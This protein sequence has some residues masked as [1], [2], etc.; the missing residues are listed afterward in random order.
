[1]YVWSGVA[2]YLPEGAVREVLSFVASH[3]SP[4]SSILFDYCFREVIE[5]DDSYYGARE[6]LHQVRAIGEPLRSGIP[7]GQTADYLGGLGLRLEQDLGPKDAERYLIRSDG[8]LYGRPY[9][10]GGIAHARVAG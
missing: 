9:G 4:Q 7:Q 10:F 3:G 2:P 1:L 8:S 6:L 5:G